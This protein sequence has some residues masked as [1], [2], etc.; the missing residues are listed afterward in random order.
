[1]YLWSIQEEEVWELIQDT[2]IYRCDPYK[3]DLLKPMQ[4]ELAGKELD[5]Q[6]EAAYEWLTKQ[7]EKRVG[8]RPDGVRFPV[9]AWYQYSWKRKPDL[10]KERWTNGS[11]GERLACIEL[12]VPDDQV[13]LSDFNAWHS[14]LSRW[15]IS[16]TEEESDKI[17]EYLDHADEAEEEVFL[18]KNWER[19]LDI[20]PF[21]NDWIRRGED[22]QATFWELKKE[23]VKKVRLFIAGKRK[24]RG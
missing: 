20:T 19:A 18:Q 3:S 5:P 1:M 13:L 11:G 8:P 24:D 12:D 23:Y 16:D 9:W 2:G 6:F 10:R 14:V 21:K 22:V 17:H 7:M 15:P 4:D